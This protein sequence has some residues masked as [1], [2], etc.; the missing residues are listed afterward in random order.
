M[1]L[2]MGTGHVC[3]CTTIQVSLRGAYKR[4]PQHRSTGHA[5]RLKGLFPGLCP[6]LCFSGWM[7]KQI[8]AEAPMPSTGCP[9]HSSWGH[10]KP[11]IWPS[12]PVWDTAISPAAFLMSLI[13]LCQVTQDSLSS[14]HPGTF[15]SLPCSTVTYWRDTCQVLSFS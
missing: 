12:S 4:S 3:Q 8:L 2:P 11:L 6:G 14:W 7:E 5:G 13:P 1:S 15:S 10:E 9:I